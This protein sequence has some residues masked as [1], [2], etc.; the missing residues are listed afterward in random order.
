MG[1][2]IAHYGNDMRIQLN[3][4]GLVAASVASNGALMGSQQAKSFSCPLG[5]S[6]SGG[7]LDFDVFAPAGTAK[8]QIG[9]EFVSS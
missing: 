4:A 7:I 6:N 8:C 5:L 2:A 1:S 3:D 9:L